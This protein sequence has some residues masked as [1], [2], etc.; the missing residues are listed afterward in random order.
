MTLGL[1]GKGRKVDIWVA[2]D[3][4]VGMLYKLKG[5]EVPDPPKVDV[6]IDGLAKGKEGGGDGL[7]DVGAAAAKGF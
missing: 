4:Y 6:H 5:V 2:S 7:L 1:G 3:G